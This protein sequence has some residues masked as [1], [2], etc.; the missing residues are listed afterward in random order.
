M[1]KQDLVYKVSDITGIERAACAIIIDETINAIQNSL[2]KGE[3]VTLRGLFTLSVIKRKSKYA[4]NISKGT[5]VIIPETSRPRAKFA[6]SLI[7]R[8]SKL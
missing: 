1:T 2:A 8:I 3:K 6:K 7:T 5:S 4:R